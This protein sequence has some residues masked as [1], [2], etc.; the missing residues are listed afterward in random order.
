MSERTADKATRRRD[1]APAG[2]P[3][4]DTAVRPALKDRIAGALSVAATEHRDNANPEAAPRRTGKKQPRRARLRLSRIDPWSVMKAS[5]L[6][7]IAF[8]VVTFVAV[9][10]I[11]SVLGAAGV[12]DSINSTVASVI[13][14]D[15]PSD[16][17]VTNY[18]GMSRVL[19]F[20][21][22]IS[23]IDVIL[24]TAI[25]TL[26]AFLY[27]MAAALLGGVEVTLSED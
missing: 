25:A 20:T 17:D 14:G 7:S 23:V 24:L 21:L 2:D 22:L 26:G 9:F 19:G 10:M 1:R 16:F 15:Q 3:T 11:W 12:W 13:E 27:N 6:L 8:G 4:G 18:V 5:F